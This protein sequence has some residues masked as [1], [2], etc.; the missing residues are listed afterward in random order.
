MLVIPMFVIISV[1]FD[2]EDRVCAV[3]EYCLDTRDARDAE[4]R[5]SGAGNKR[6]MCDAA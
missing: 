5:R 1:A 2:H 6:L 3:I 4:T